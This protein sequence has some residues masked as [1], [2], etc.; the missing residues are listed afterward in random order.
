M[1]SA[2][3]TMVA[4]FVGGTIWVCTIVHGLASG[5][6]IDETTLA[7]VTAR[8]V[9]LWIP[10]VWV[11]WGAADPSKRLALCAV[12]AVI[13]AMPVIFISLIGIKFSLVLFLFLLF[14]SVV[15]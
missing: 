10:M 3:L 8:V 15:L 14:I 5:W 7:T 4:P 1:F 6:L 2:V 11:A 12:I 9:L 13:V